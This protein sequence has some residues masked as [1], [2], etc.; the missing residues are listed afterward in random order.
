MLKRL[1]LKD[2]NMNDNSSLTGSGADTPALEIRHVVKSFRG[3]KGKRVRAV[4]DL[5]LTV[6]KGEIVALLG[7][8]GAGKTVTLDMV[9]GLS[10]PD[11]G[12]LSV[13]GVRPKDCLL[14]TSDAADE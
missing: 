3:P 7:P 8:N 4:N 5:S 6:G 11:S 1:V 14:Y 12:S 10:Q 2:K 13:L 9:L